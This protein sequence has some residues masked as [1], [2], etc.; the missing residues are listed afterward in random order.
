MLLPLL[1]NGPVS[2]FARMVR[3]QECILEQFD[4]YQ[5]QSYR[6]RCRIVGPNGPIDLSIPVLRKHGQKTLMKDVRVDYENH[7]N[8]IH[9]KSLEASYA[10]SPYFEYFAADY[11]LLY[12]RN[13]SFLVDLNMD[14]LRL[15]LDCL[16]LHPLLQLSADFTAI[17]AIDPREFIHPKKKSQEEDPEFNSI[18]YHQVFT[19][20]HGFLADLSILDLLFNLGPDAPSLL[21]ASLKT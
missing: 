10:S 6:N 20:R 1:Y 13:Y 2:Y 18:P 3:Q 15:A 5:K 9:W 19:E 21:R 14:F 11:E 4:S 8:R 16:D 7:W 17:S 12:R